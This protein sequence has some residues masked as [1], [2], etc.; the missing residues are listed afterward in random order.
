M[1]SEHALMNWPNKYL[2][3]FYQQK[4]KLMHISQESVVTEYYLEEET[5]K[6][7]YSKLMRKEILDSYE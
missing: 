7:G 2:S 1:Y 4:C 5:K 6:H 3:E